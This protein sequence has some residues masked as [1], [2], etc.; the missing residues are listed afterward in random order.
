MPFSSS[1][2]CATGRQSQRKKRKNV[3]I[4]TV[5]FVIHLGNSHILFNERECSFISSASIEK[6]EKEKK[7]GSGCN[8][9]CK[10]LD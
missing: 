9:R 10:R 8:I 1:E 3:V 7:R 4:I 6:K 2:N 5:M